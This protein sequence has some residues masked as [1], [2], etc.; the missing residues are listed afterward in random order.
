MIDFK[1]LT[2]AVTVQTT[3]Q[4]STAM[5]CKRCNH[6]IALDY[7]QRL[8]VVGPDGKIHGIITS[9]HHTGRCPECFCWFEWYRAR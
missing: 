4:D 9:K 6:R 1:N 3:S 7:R 8:E 2:P 5:H